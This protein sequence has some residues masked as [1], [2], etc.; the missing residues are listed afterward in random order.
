MLNSDLDSLVYVSSAVTLL[1]LDEIRSLVQRARE[2]NQEHDITGVLLY[3]NGN[4]MQYLE[5][6]KDSLNIIYRDIQEDARHTGLI[7]IAREAIESRLFADWSLGFLS[8]YAELD[9]ESP[10]EIKSIIKQLEHPGP[11][12]S[13]AQI[14]LNRFWRGIGF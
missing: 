4:F 9:L 13:T 7:L 8:Q 11:D 2:R 12:P 1:D 5:G 14:V 3:N 6:P 10:D